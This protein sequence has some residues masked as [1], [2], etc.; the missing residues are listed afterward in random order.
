MRGNNDQSNLL[1]KKYNYQFTS[2]A[3]PDFFVTPWSDP[4]PWSDPYGPVLTFRH[5][6]WTASITAQCFHFEWVVDRASR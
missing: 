2:N 5:S 3:A 1:L 4:S 6:D